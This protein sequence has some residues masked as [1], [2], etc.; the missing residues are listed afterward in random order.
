MNFK[1]K[2]TTGFATGTAMVT[3][4]STAA[5]ANVTVNGNGPFSSNSVLVSE[6]TTTVV[7]Q[8]NSTNVVN[9]VNT[10]SNTG[11]N[12][13]SSNVGGSGNV[14]SGD[15]TTNV[16]VSNVG[17]S[18]TATVSGCGCPADAT[19]VKVNGNGPF[20][21]NSVVVS[22]NKM[23][24]FGQHNSFNAYN[25]VN[26]TSNTGGNSSSFNVMSNKTVKSGNVTTNVTVKNKSGHNMLM[27]TP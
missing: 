25:G 12:S 11:N 3:V 24:V 6:N 18:N 7:S 22:K 17:G 4:F 19:T 5:F 27:V 1:Q 20:S 8:S 10:V 26:T 13:S 15:V 21:N 23:S 9:S 14:T 2:L 16:T